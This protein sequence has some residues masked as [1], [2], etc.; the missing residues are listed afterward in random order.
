MNTCPECGCWTEHIYDTRHIN[1]VYVH[2]VSTYRCTCGHVSYGIPDL[3]GLAR[4]LE[5]WPGQD[6]EHRCGGWGPL[7]WPCPPPPLD[8]A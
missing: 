4:A 5:I 3:E 1:G 7:L 6:L 8:V 2:C